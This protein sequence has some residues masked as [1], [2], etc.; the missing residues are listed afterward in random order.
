MKRTI[1]SAVLALVLVLGSAWDHAAFAQYDQSGQ[2]D[3]QREVSYQDFYDQL[4]P[5]GQW[6][7]HPDYGYVWIPDAGPDF[8]PYSTEG[9]WVW[10]EDA[11]W[12]WV[13]DYDWGWAPFHYG[14]WDQDPYYGWFWVPG[15]EWSPAW[16]A[17]RDGG[18]YY[19]W[20]PIR[21][22]INVDINFNMGTYAP[23]YEFWSFTPRR[24][25]LY[26]RVRDYCIDYR[27][28]YSI[29]S[30][31]TVISFN[32]G[33]RWGYRSGPR[34]WEAER[35]C[36]PIRPVRFRDSY[37][38]GRTYFR[39]NE[40]RL[41]RPNVRRDEGRG[42]APQRFER[43]D[44]NNG[45]RGNRG[46]NGNGR[47]ENGGRINNGN[48]NGRPENGGRNNGFGRN[49]NGNRDNGRIREA[50]GGRPE[51]RDFRTNGNGDRSQGAGNPNMNG[52]RRTERTV[53][54]SGNNPGNGRGFDRQPQQQPQTPRQFERRN[55]NGRNN[56]GTNSGNNRQVE[57]RSNAGSGNT[58]QPRF[59]RQQPAQPRY[60]RQPQSQPQN[61]SRQFERRN[62]NGGG[63]NGGGNRQEG[64]NGRRRF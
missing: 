5:Y 2:Y 45:F 22:G 63:N 12:M 35:Y 42:Y 41:Y 29:F 17:W 47:F 37:T 8:R 33:G 14:R 4:S 36:G 50:Q 7:D 58:N 61:P 59:E 21:P 15:Y 46:N 60:D 19:G 20:A 55:E 54:N 51:N 52:G 6:V 9:N 10:T 53:N 44:R 1:Q 18:D 13:S 57:R 56:P 39:D 16:V 34:R 62:D 23:P 32:I 48:G 43:Y 28:N 3:R 24:Y 38:P 26:P 30:M 25:I 11:E 27:R 31:T 64:G 49:D 40:V